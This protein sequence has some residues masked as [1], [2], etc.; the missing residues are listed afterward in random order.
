MLLEGAPGR[1]F[2]FAAEGGRGGEYESEWDGILRNV[3]R[4]FRETVRIASAV[5][6]A[7]I[8]LEE[9]FE[10][11]ERLKVTPFGFHGDAAFERLLRDGRVPERLEPGA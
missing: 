10:L 7:R 2:K 4:R 1:T 8:A 11:Y 5:E 3:E 9:N 6:A